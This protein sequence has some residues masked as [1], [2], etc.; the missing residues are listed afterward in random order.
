M[1][2]TLFYQDKPL[3]GLDI[4][5]RTVKVM[6]ADFS[7][8]RHSVSGYGITSFD[9]N[10]IENGVIVDFD[11]IASS[12]HGLFSKGLT[13]EISTRRVAVSVPASKT[14]SRIF[15]LPLL[16]QKDIAEAVRLEAEQYIPV[17]IDDLYIDFMVINTGVKTMDILAVAVPKTIINS[18]VKLC[19]ILG[20]EPVVMETTTGATNR[21]FRYTDQHDIPTVLIDFGAVA[22]DISIYDKYL[23]VTGTVAGGGD[24]IT[25]LI[26]GSLAVKP[27]EAEIIKI[28]YG[29]AMSKKQS[30]IVA[31]V[32]PLLE[33][34]IKEVRRMIR[35]YEERTDNRGKIEQIVTFGG[36]ANMP[37]LSEFLIDRLRVPVR[38]CDPWHNIVFKHLQPPNPIEQSL[39]ITAASL[40]I[41]KPGEAFS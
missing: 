37:G 41:I 4:G 29:L 6:Q 33:K 17:P 35:Y 13:G 24:D 14:F 12:I 25:D 11:S 8:K 5:F 27:Q 20:L 1:D 30:E 7:G 2:K 18:Y 22:T 40:A 16:A 21:L 26:A 28:K 39:Y 31:A 36:A 23:A 10:A 19:D 3:F 9:Q 38:A 34:T 15:S 32:E